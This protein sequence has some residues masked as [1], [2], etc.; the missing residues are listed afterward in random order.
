MEGQVR[1]IIAEVRL[2]RGR[3]ADAVD[4]ADRAVAICQETGHR[5]G[6]ARALRVLGDGLAATGRERAA[7]AAWQQARAL[8]AELGMPASGELAHQVRSSVARPETRP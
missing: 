3:P 2:A 4:A 8:L 5:P 7:E 6:E 1:T